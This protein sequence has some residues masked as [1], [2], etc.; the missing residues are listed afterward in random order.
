MREWHT[1]TVPFLSLDIKS[2]WT[3]QPVYHQTPQHVITALLL[4]LDAAILI[5]LYFSLPLCPSIVCSLSPF[6]CQLLVF[7]CGVHVMGLRGRKWCHPVLT[8]PFMQWVFLHSCQWFSLFLTWK[9]QK[10]IEIIGPFLWNDEPTVLN[11]IEATVL[12]KMQ[13]MEELK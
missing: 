13:K 4:S 6:P 11:F 2:D 10:H 12:N 1:S 3:V 7:L 5:A 9:L 8:Y